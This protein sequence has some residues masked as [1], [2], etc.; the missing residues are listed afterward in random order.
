MATDQDDPIAGL[1]S[2]LKGRTPLEQLKFWRSFKATHT[3]RI[4]HTEAQLCPELLRAVDNQI[5][6]LKR[7]V[8]QGA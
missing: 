1:L 7:L 6:E 8:A 5:N 2:F 3:R 4:A